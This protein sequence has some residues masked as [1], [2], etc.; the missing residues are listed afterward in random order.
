[1][2]ACNQPAHPARKPLE[3]GATPEMHGDYAFFRDKKGEKEGTRTVLVMVDRKSAGICA[4]V[5]PKKGVGGGFAVKQVHRDMRKFGHRHKITLRSDGEPAIKDLFEK[6]AS[7]C[8]PETLLENSPVGDSRANGRAERAVQSVE[9]QVRALK[10][11]TE[12]N[13]GEFSVSHPCFA[14]LV[15]HA[16]DVITKFRVHPDGST[17]YERLGIGNIQ[18]SC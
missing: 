1:M 16:A 10:L 6:V 18:G 3:P 11:A 9:K 17:S 12:K 15:N 5:V 13:L 8:A 14:W 2:G 4:N 7:M